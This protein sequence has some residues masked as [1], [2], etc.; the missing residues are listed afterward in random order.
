MPETAQLPHPGVRLFRL[1]PCQD[2]DP[3]RVPES[4]LAIV[5]E[6]LT[7]ARDRAWTARPGRASVARIGGNVQEIGE[8]PL[9]LGQRSRRLGHSSLAS[10]RKRLATGETALRLGETPSGLGE[11]LLTPP[12]AAARR[13]DGRLTAYRTRSPWLSEEDMGFAPGSPGCIR[14]GRAWCP[15][16]LPTRGIKHL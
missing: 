4:L 14:A 11:T 3:P 5:A 7:G 12:R 10:G 15:Q 2:G 9:A 13:P 6:A 1:P 8:T 16:R